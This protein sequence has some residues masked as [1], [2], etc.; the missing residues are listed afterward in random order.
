VTQEPKH[1]LYLIT[2]AL[3]LSLFALIFWKTWQYWQTPPT[4]NLT[5][6]HH[7]SPNKTQGLDNLHLF[8]KTADL[9]NL[10]LSTLPFIIQGIAYSEDTNSP[11]IVILQINNQINAYQVGQSLAPGI[12]L[13]A[14]TPNG[15]IISEHDEL[16]R[17]ILPKTPTL[18]PKLLTP[19]LRPN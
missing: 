13:V 16:S 18:T 17:L 10:P 1:W 19:E 15:I 4:I 5:P 14:I 2:L 6:A 9:A 7:T 12:M 11:S 3:G 8:G